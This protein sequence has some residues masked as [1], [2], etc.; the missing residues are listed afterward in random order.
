LKPD[1]WVELKSPYVNYKA[2]NI[3][4]QSI[5]RENC[6][7]SRTK[8][9]SE[10]VIKEVEELE[11]MYLEVE[12]KNQELPS[13]Q[14]LQKPKL[15]LTLNIISEKTESEL[16]D[17]SKSKQEKINGQNLLKGKSTNKIDREK[18]I[19]GIENIVSFIYM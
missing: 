3:A 17:S 5:E 4:N 7:F 16:S 6:K 8:S 11:V 12:R 14:E 19:D 10:S 13:F 18:S 15:D 2:I 9:V 1:Q